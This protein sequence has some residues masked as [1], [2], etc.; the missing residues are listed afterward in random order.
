MFIHN[1]NNLKRRDGGEAQN[2]GI[3]IERVIDLGSMDFAH[4]EID[5]RNGGFKLNKHENSE[6]VMNAVNGHAIANSL[7]KVEEDDTSPSSRSSISTIFMKDTSYDNQEKEDDPALLARNHNHRLIRRG[8]FF[9]DLAHGFKTFGKAVKNGFKAFGKDVKKIGK[10]IIHTVKK[11]AKDIGHMFHEM[12]VDPKHM[13]KHF[14]QG[15]TAVGQDTVKG[16]GQVIDVVIQSPVDIM[17]AV[18]RADLVFFKPLND[19]A[20]AL[21][22]YVVHPLH[23]V[24]RFVV[25]TVSGIIGII[26][27]ILANIEMLPKFLWELL[28]AVFNWDGI[29]RVSRFVNHHLGLMAPYSQ[30]MIER[31][32]SKVYQSFDDMCSLITGGC[33]S[34]PHFLSSVGVSTGSS[35]TS[36]AKAPSNLR[37]SNAGDMT[38]IVQNNND[39][40][41][42]Y[43]HDT[44]T[45]KSGI[46]ATY[47]RDMTPN[48]AGSLSN[49]PLK[50]KDHHSMSDIAGIIK[51]F[52][53]ESG[54]EFKAMGRAFE[55]C[56]NELKQKMA[57][58]LKMGDVFHFLKELFDVV[59]RGVFQFVALLLVKI[60]EI[61]ITFFDSILSYHINIPII[62]WLYESV[63]MKGTEQL[64]LYS[65]ASLAAAI[66]VFAVGQAQSK[67]WENKYQDGEFFSQT[68]LD[69]LLAIQDPSKY[70]DAWM[71]DDYDPNVGILNIN[72]LL[73][74]KR[75]VLSY[76]IGSAAVESRFVSSILGS[77]DAFDFTG[78]LY[79]LRGPF[80][81]VNVICSYPLDWLYLGLNPKSSI[82]LPGF[83]HPISQDELRFVPW[84]MKL[85]TLVTGFLPA[86]NNA[87]TPFGWFI[88]VASLVLQTA[89]VIA[90][91]VRDI[92]INNSGQLK[93][94]T[95]LTDILMKAFSNILQ[96]L[97]KVEKQIA[98]PGDPF[99]IIGMGLDVAGATGHVARL[100]IDMMDE[101]VF[102]V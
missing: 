16:I 17:K 20:N 65:L 18:A 36:L 56:W 9:H 1:V 63:L 21:E 27:G 80:D 95:Y 98:G 28:K 38:D 78:L 32:F 5:F 31:E 33:S 66:P 30:M 97:G 82:H 62:S 88:L 96:I 77:T 84:F 41:L 68:D 4:M 79:I 94:F 75:N 13:W 50:P 92:S 25:S 58:G 23:G 22:T 81:F 42:S 60:S 39:H 74:R 76:I 47:L 24:I 45:S 11:D 46:Q 19:L 2:D 61:M 72:P 53:T 43:A 3:Y 51:S 44:R 85:T 69:I 102:S 26:G 89:A 100:G 73:A 54:V 29:L 71:P 99:I 91:F 55:R 15:I 12:I 37:V 59:L 83:K 6:S 64:T 70:L 57:R 87:I 10:T 8:G 40:S 7:A 34:L 93:S 48:V 101:S 90:V 86:S 67:T 49:M 52:I 35:M 14:W